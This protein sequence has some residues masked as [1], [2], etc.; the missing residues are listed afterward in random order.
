M[1]T[2]LGKITF[3]D[4]PDVSGDLLIK[5]T[6][7]TSQLTNIAVPG[8]EGITLPNGT[9]AQRPAAPQTGESRFNTTISLPEIYAQG[10]WLPYARVIQTASGQITQQ[11]SAANYTLAAAPPVYTFGAQLWSTTFTPLV[12]GSNLVVQYSVTA[13][14]G[15]TARTAYTAAYVGTA[16]SGCI[17]M[18]ISSIVA[19]GYTVLTLQAVY[20]TTSTAA[21]AIRAMVGNVGSA[22]TTYF[23][24]TTT[25][26]TISSALLTEWRILEII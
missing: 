5:Q 25:A 21:L 11:T 17:G 8:T 6:D 23:G 16:A 18:A 15:T 3:L 13:A 14:G 10:T 12:S 2:A 24:Q 22:Q 4:T 9:T 20:T 7:L 1:T 26:S 19:S